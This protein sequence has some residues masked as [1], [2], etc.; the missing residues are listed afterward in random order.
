MGRGRDLGL[1]MD[2]N[3]FRL[4]LDYG[5]PILFVYFDSY[6]FIFVFIFIVHL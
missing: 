5:P 3:F 4:N 6:I 2:K 1:R